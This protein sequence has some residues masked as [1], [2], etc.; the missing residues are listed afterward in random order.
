MIANSSPPLTIVPTPTHKTSYTLSKLSWVPYV[1]FHSMRYGYEWVF[2][3]FT[4]F[5]RRDEI[6]TSDSKVS[7]I[8]LMVCMYLSGV[9]LCNTLMQFVWLSLSVIHQNNTAAQLHS[10]FSGPVSHTC[11]A[12]LSQFLLIKWWIAMTVSVGTS[13]HQGIFLSDWWL[14]KIYND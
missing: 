9:Y 13:H 1:K 3:L 8:L 12:L 7:D 11:V 4:F 2:T 6:D 10:L 5:S 14:I